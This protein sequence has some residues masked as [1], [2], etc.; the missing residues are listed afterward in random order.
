MIQKRITCRASC[1]HPGVLCLQES[2]LMARLGY[3]DILPQKTNLLWFFSNGQNP[4]TLKNIKLLRYWITG[5]NFKTLTRYL[6]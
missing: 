4:Q 1:K 6:L 3:T 2:E 5:V